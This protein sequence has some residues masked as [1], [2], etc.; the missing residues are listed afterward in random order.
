MTIVIVNT[1]PVKVLA[2]Q[3]STVIKIAEGP[4]GVGIPTGGSTNQVLR[5]VSNTDYDLEWANAFTP[6]PTYVIK[7]IPT[8]TVVNTDGSLENNYPGA[9]FLLEASPS[10]GR[11]FIIYNGTLAGGLTINGNG[12]N[13]NGEA[14]LYLI[15]Y[16]SVRLQFN[17]TQWRIS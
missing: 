3:E 2:N 10:T 16:D 4:R 15:N 1:N 6:S 17:G 5:K 13:I 9:T 11:E 8:Y 14:L 7:N 12:K